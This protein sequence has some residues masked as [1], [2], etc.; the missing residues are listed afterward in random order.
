MYV[1]VY[2]Y[3]RLHA[4]V[5][6]YILPM[7]MRV[8]VHACVRACVCAQAQAP[9]PL[10]PKDALSIGMV[11]DKRTEVN[12]VRLHCNTLQHTAKEKHGG[13]GADAHGVYMCVHE[14]VCVLCVCMFVCLGL[15]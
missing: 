13:G 3:I 6:M 15:L 1:Y 11:P 7:Y 9:A 12:K 2:I 5:C 14:R 10:A 4:H 8:C